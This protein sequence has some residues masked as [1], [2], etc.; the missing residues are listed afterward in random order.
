MQ[1]PGGDLPHLEGP[2]QSKLLWDSVGW[3]SRCPAGLALPK[4]GVWV[5]S[6]DEGSGQDVSQ[7]PS[8]LRAAPSPSCSPA[9]TSVS[10]AAQPGTSPQVSCGVRSQRSSPS[11]RGEKETKKQ[12]A[13][14]CQRWVARACTQQGQ[15]SVSGTRQCCRW[16]CVGQQSQR[17]SHAG[18]PAH[19]ASNPLPL[20]APSSCPAS[21][22]VF[23]ALSFLLGHLQ[24]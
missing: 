15:P 16:R 17:R 6:V 24:L 13:G 1:A 18:A 8:R 10:P 4:V 21:R 7:G 14:E 22:L 11:R 2:W 19:V 20:P 3:L 12:D 9:V 5:P 23:C